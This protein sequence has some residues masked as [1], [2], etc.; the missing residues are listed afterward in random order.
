MKHA[1]KRRA[2]GLVTVLAT[3]A[4]LAGCS[5]EKKETPPPEETITNP[6]EVTLYTSG[7]TALSVESSL[8][9]IYNYPEDETQPV[10]STPMF[11]IDISLPSLETAMDWVKY[12][13]GEVQINKTEFT[14]K[15]ITSIEV[16]ALS[17]YD[18]AHPKGSSLNDLMELHYVG[19]DGRYY[20]KMDLTEF[21]NTYGTLSWEPANG[22][23][24]VFRL[25][26]RTPPA[27]ENELTFR[28]AHFTDK[29]GL[30]LPC[31]VVTVKIT[32]EDGTTLSID[33]VPG[34][35]I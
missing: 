32:M 6:T 33:P 10:Q 19:S 15:N 34:Q 13:Y 35:K 4:I 12:A 11:D 2:M 14:P 21:F 20:S 30:P 16:I 25:A 17:D 9:Y 3:T 23:G 22:V 29:E 27:K 5:K 24:W 18:A 8:S 31:F 1:L 7:N 28:P 26:A